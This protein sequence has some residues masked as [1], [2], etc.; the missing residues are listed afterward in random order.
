MII[1]TRDENYTIKFQLINQNPDRK[2]IFVI[3]R[4]NYKLMGIISYI[5][6]LLLFLPIFISI[7]FVTI[8]SLTHNQIGWGII[9]IFIFFTI[10]IGFSKAFIWDELKMRN[11]I[12]TFYLNQNQLIYEIISF[13]RVTTKYWE[14]NN[15]QFFQTKS[16]HT[17]STYGGFTIYKLSLTENSESTNKLITKTILSKSQKNIIDGLAITLKNNGFDVI[18]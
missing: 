3:D 14:L 2:E 16:V 17:V 11:D 7:V 18:N 1:Q 13:G 5:M 4:E 8:F 6:I 15:F 10:L 9:F 12:E